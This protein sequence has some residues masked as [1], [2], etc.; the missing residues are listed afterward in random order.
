MIKSV[1][2]SLEI[3]PCGMGDAE[4]I[5]EVAIRS[6]KDFYLRLWHDDGSWYID[7]SFSL[8]VI[9]K[10]LKDPNHVFFLLKEA[11]EPIGF[12]KLNLNQP[13]SGFDACDCIELERIYLIKSATWKGYG[14]QAMNFCLDYAN[15]VNKDIIWLKAMDTSDAVGFYQAIGFHHCGTKTLDFSMMKKEFRGM[16]IMMKRLSKI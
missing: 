16:V 1:N 14:R 3:I 5:S 6:Y 12:L 11:E 8:P 4:I 9:E 13:L 10:E 2:V 15:E 7:R